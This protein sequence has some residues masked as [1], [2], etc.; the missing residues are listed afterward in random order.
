MINTRAGS[1]TNE[2]QDV[3]FV[4]ESII[5]PEPWVA[6]AACAEVPPDIFFPETSSTLTGVAQRICAVCTVAD[7][8]LGFALRNNEE[9]GVWGGLSAQELKRLR[10]RMRTAT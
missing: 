5:K 8:C 3:S 2:E 10:R 4:G 6:D 7:E 9:F 1:F